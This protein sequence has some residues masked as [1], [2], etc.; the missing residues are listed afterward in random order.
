MRSQGLDRNVESLQ[1][2]KEGREQRV[3]LGVFRLGDDLRRRISLVELSFY[4]KEETVENTTPYRDGFAE[5]IWHSYRMSAQLPSA[6]AECL[7]FPA[8]GRINDYTSRHL[9]SAGLL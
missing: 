7:T 3:D 6:S 2:T 4:R 9:P 8:P 1:R 5:G